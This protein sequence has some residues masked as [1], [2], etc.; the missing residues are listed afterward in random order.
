MKKSL[1]L[2]TVI[3][4]LAI[5]PAGC[6][7]KEALDGCPTAT[8]SLEKPPATPFETPKATP[9]PTATAAPA[10]TAGS[11]QTVVSAFIA[12]QDAG[13]WASFQSLWTTG[14]QLYYRD[15]FAHK[16][17]ATKRNGYFAIQS[18]HVVSLYEIKDFSR[19]LSKFSISDL[20][21]DVWYAFNAYDALERYP[22]VK[23]LIAKADYHLDSE[24]WDYR[25]GVNY[26]VF[27]L[28]P[29]D[30]EWRVMQNYQGYP[31]AGD[32]FGDTIEEPEETEEPYPEETPNTLVD[33]TVHST[34][35]TTGYFIGTEIGD[36]VHVGIRTI[37]GEDLWFW[38]EGRCE[39]DPDT[40]SHY[41]KVRVVWENRDTY[42]DEAEEVINMDIITEIEILE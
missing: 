24:F 17:N 41:Q 37:E 38:I 12:A 16:D 5:L 9:S 15:F 3:L 36:Y 19:L 39:T 33:G 26:R 13:D 42:I 20:P 6:K 31:S 35:S 29:E 23:L 18:A 28:V 11:A 4:L 1:A 34:N 22:D 27:V 8:S 40:L 30:G 21:F 25:E 14:E 7:P 32:Y 10:E 2:L